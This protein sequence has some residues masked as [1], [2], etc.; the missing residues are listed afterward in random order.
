M[1]WDFSLVG[2][3]PGPLTFGWPSYS[4][5]LLCQVWGVPGLPT[6]GWPSHSPILLCQVWGVP[7]L[8]TFGWTS[9]SPI[10]LC[11]VWGVPGL[12]TFGWPS[13][14]PISEVSRVSGL[15]TLLG[16]INAAPQKKTQSVDVKQNKSI[17]Q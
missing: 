13:Y 7:G 4:L 8:P 14:S 5:I 1:S 15:P 12:P 17:N 11:Q 2:Q 16:P 9:Y 10:L 6:F 3:G